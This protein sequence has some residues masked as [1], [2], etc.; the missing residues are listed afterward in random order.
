MAR[1]VR[2]SLPEWTPFA[3]ALR[4]AVEETWEVWS[5]VDADAT[6]RRRLNDGDLGC[7]AGDVARASLPE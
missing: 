2:Q 4:V 6:T 3:E 5:G 7:Y 1:A